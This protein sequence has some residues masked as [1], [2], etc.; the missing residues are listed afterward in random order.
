[1]TL[2]WAIYGGRLEVVR[3]LVTAGASLHLME[4]D[5]EQ[6]IE[7]YNPIVLAVHEEQPE[8]AVY[9]LGQVRATEGV[10]EE[11]LFAAFMLSVEK[12][13]SSVVQ[14]CIEIGVDIDRSTADGRTAL[15]RSLQLELSEMAELLLA[16]G[17]DPN[18]AGPEGLVPIFIAI[19]QGNEGLVSLLIE[20]GADPATTVSPVYLS[21]PNSSARSVDIEEGI[22][23]L[24][25]ASELG[26][27]E[28]VRIIVE[29]ESIQDPWLLTDAIAAAEAYEHEGIMHYLQ[30]Y[31]QELES[32]EI[33]EEQNRS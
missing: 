6:R 24:T 23:A 27:R 14:V 2:E 7:R 12:N 26:H 16:S 29:S 17:A 19:T 25:Y 5:G 30:Q 18:H 22:T 33:R 8:I 32:V 9:L 11:D 1:Y 31:M 10:F 15:I 13:F 21:A 20:E 3:R 28:I 4:E